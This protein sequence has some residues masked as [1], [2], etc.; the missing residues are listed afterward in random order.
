MSHPSPNM[1]HSSVE[2]VWGKPQVLFKLDSSDSLVLIGNVLLPIGDV[3]K[4]RHET[5][6]TAEIMYHKLVPDQ[7]GGDKFKLEL[8]H[9]VVFQPQNKATLD[10]GDDGASVALQASAAGMVPHSKWETGD[11]M[12]AW[13][14]QWKA[15]G[16]MPV[17]PTVVFRRAG[18]LP[19]GRS[20]L[21]Q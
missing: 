11:T 15:K 8:V 9:N 7:E 14:V 1:I 19:A 17:R 20:L 12:I 18:A 2:R 6:P 10:D 13:A 3:L 4:S 5:H 21:L 16:L